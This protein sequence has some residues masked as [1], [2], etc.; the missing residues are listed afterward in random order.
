MT[1]YLSKLEIKQNRTGFRFLGNPYWVHQQVAEATAGDHRPL[2]RIENKTSIPY[3]LVQSHVI[4]DW[5]KTIEKTRAI[6]RTHT[7]EMDLS[8]IVGGKRFYFR[9]L[10]NPVADSPDGKRTAL[11]DDESLTEWLERKMAK[12]GSELIYFDITQKGSQVCYKPENED[13]YQRIIHNCVMF[14]GMLM[15][16]NPELLKNAVDK[17][18]GRAKGFGMGLLSLIHEN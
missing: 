9:L 4:P 15:A 12:A 18:L 5:T 10:G 1:L 7:R 13:D 8:K 6:E 2:F 17:G 16:K 14:E 11:L 3:L